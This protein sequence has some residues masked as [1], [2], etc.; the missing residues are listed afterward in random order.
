MTVY[1]NYKYYGINPLYLTSSLTSLFFGSSFHP[2]TGRSH[3]DTRSG[4]SL[5]CR[6]TNEHKAD[7]QT[8]HKYLQQ[9]NMHLVVNC[10]RRQ[11][12]KISLFI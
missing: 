3:R 2:T 6:Y 12:I 11:D 1:D 9:R 5:V 4:S 10:Q 7:P 8:L